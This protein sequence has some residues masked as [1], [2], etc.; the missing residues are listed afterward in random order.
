VAK[1]NSAKGGR[2]EK[3]ECT[4][5][6]KIRIGVPAKKMLM[7]IAI[8]NERTLA[9]QIRLAINEWIKNNSKVSGATHV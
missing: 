1:V 8:E 5:V 4:D 2:T 6:V 3:A 9:G 7:K